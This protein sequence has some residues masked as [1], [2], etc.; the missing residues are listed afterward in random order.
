MF[1]ASLIDI[2]AAVAPRDSFDTLMIIGVV[3]GVAFLYALSRLSERRN[4]KA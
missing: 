3:V 2:T 4:P 1:N